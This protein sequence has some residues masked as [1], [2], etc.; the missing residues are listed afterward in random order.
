MGENRDELKRMKDS[1][2]DIAPPEKGIFLMKD[3]ISRAREERRRRRKK[4]IAK[5]FGWG[6]AVA[7][8]AILVVLPNLSP[9]AA[10]AMSNMPILRN[11][12][13]AVDFSR[14][15]VESMDA[16]F[17]ADV[18]VPKLI[19]CETDG[20]RFDGR[21]CGDMDDLNLYDDALSSIN[22]EMN[23]ISNGLVREF[24]ENMDRNVGYEDLMIRYEILST[25]E[26]YFTMKLI[27]YVGAG[28]G[29]ERDYFYTIG[30]RSGKRLSLEDLF[31]PGSDYR[32]LISEN[33]KT[34]MREQMAEKEG[35]VYWLADSEYGDIPEWNFETID[36]DQ[37]FYINEDG[38]IVIAFSEGDVGPM[39]MGTTEFVIPDE[40]TAQIRVK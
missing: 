18:T 6:G 16:R 35:I 30:L 4:R 40:V 9:D 7:A 5:S 12:V 28:S 31:I 23:L 22:M 17:T 10:Y 15:E 24:Q 27:T 39:S 25:T 38:Q 37:N 14:Y 19:A 33:I 36:R 1:Y 20:S 32:S 21:L 34:Q 3:A 2:E 13:E 8:L 11:I 29:Y 26:D